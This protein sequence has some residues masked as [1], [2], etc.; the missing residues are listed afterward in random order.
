MHA[1]RLPK[2]VQ[3][4][5]QCVLFEINHPNTVMFKL[6]DEQTLARDINGKMINAPANGA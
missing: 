4:A 2:A 6:R 1:L 3:R 5:R